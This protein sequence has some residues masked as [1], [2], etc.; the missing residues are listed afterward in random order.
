MTD[1]GVSPFFAK[2]V[3]TCNEEG[4]P[5]VT[6]FSNKKEAIKYF[7]GADRG[8]GPSIWTLAKVKDTR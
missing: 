4:Y 8:W 6:Y 7:E 2:W 5:S 3:V 1:V